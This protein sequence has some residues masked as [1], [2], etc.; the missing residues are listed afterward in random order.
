MAARKRPTLYSL[1]PGRRRRRTYP[2]V[3][4]LA[5]LAAGAAVLL[6]VLVGYALWVVR[7]LL[8]TGAGVIDT[9]KS[10]VR[11]PID[12]PES[13]APTGR[14]TAL[15][16]GGARTRALPGV[17]LSAGILVD[18]RSGRVLWLQ[19]AHDRRAIASL[20]KL[21]TAHVIAR[22]PLAGSFKVTA[23]AL[24]LPGESLGLAAGQR[25]AV[26]DM[27]AATLVS[28]ANDAAAAL[29]IHRAGSVPRFARLMNA[30]ARRLRLKDTRYS[31]P[32]GI[33]DQGNHSSAWD[34][35]QLTRSVLRDPRLARMVSSKVVVSSTHQDYVNTNQ[36]LW[37]YS[38]AMG[39]KTGFTD[40]SGHCLAAAATR[41]GRTLIA[42]V[43][44]TDRSEFSTAARVLDWGFRHAG[45]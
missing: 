29:A 10:V 3:R 23:G 27:L 11:Q 1:E 13:P 39:V 14:L 4:P 30:E 43:L 28:S 38:G 19:H 21:M 32:S 15:V 22:S 26:R 35:A 42:V 37:T 44:D 20:T 34:V 2:R 18:A 8:D 5:A 45:R 33:Y 25:V 7:P 31:N 6:V 17:A 36:L 12:G 40:V 24:G 16:A 41:N 9:R